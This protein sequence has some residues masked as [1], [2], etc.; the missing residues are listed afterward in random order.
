MKT[1]GKTERSVSSPSTRDLFSGLLFVVWLL[2][3]AVQY[4]ATLQ[5]TESQLGREAAYES[6]G[7]LDL[8][9]VYALLVGLTAMAVLLRFLAEKPAASNV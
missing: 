1:P 4:F 9:L 2:T 3:G 8:T 7:S 5:R 6:L